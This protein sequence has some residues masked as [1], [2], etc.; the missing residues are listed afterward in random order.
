MLSIEHVVDFLRLGGLNL[1]NQAT[2]RF[3]NNLNDS[4][5]FINI[6]VFSNAIT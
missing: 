3:Y 1:N 2:E 4:I 5:K 6:A